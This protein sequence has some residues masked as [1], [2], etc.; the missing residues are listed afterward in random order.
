MQTS[1]KPAVE[2]SVMGQKFQVKSDTDEAYVHE[3]ATF[4]NERIEKVIQRTKSVASLNVA[5]LAAM[6]IADEYIKYKR[7]KGD[8]YKYLEKKVE[9]LIELIDLHL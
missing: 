4:V 9:D 2:V 8:N 5:L 3:V 7:K 6:N 1:K